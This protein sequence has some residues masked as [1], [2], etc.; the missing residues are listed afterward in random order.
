M[1]VLRTEQSERVSESVRACVMTCAEGREQGASDEHERDRT[2]DQGPGTRAAVTRI[3]SAPRERERAQRERERERAR[4]R[5]R[6]RET[7]CCEDRVP[8]ETASRV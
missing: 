3:K 7:V 2:R 1:C 6:W 8:S 4:E 5:E